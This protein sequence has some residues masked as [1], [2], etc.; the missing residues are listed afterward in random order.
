MCEPPCFRNP[1]PDVYT[2][3]TLLCWFFKLYYYS[4]HI[5]HRTKLLELATTNAQKT[6]TKDDTK[7]GGETKNKRNSTAHTRRRKV[8]LL[9]FVLFC[10]FHFSTSSL[11][12]DNLKCSS[13]R[14]CFKNSSFF[15]A[16]FLYW[17]VGCPILFWIRDYPLLSNYNLL[18][19]V[20]GTVI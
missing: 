8:M 15:P 9:F 18:C 4:F 3:S 12:S 1:I 6:I 14:K 10:F 11:Y 17:N 2:L 19:S 20:E 5:C 16:I 7:K 13:P